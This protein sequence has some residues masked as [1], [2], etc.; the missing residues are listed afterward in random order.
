MAAKIPQTKPNGGA[1]SPSVPVN[2]GKVPSVSAAPSARP[3]AQT[4]APGLSLQDY[5]RQINDARRQLDSAQ[6]S[7]AQAHGTNNQEEIGRW[8]GEINRLQG[9][10]GDLTSQQTAALKA[11]TAK[12]AKANTA[13]PATPAPAGNSKAG[14]AAPAVPVN[15]NAAAAASNT[16][17]NTAKTVAT[18]NTKKTS[19]TSNT[20]TQQKTQ[21]TATPQTQVQTQAQPQATLPIPSIDDINSQYQQRMTDSSGMIND[22]FA[23]QLA[24]QQAQ[25]KS[26]YDQNLADLEA[27]RGQIGRNYQ[28]SAND[29]AIQYERNRRNLNEQAMVNGLNTGTG[30]QQQLALNQQ[31]L[32][33]FGGLRGQE[34]QAYTNADMEL[35]KLKTNYQNQIAQAIA[36]NDFKKAAALVDNYNTQQNWLTD[37]LNQIRG[38][39]IQNFFNEQGH[40]WDVEGR[41]DTQAFNAGESQK[42]R[43]FETSERLGRQD[44][45]KAE[46]EA[47]QEYETGVRKEGYAQ[48]EK[49]QAHDD[50][51]NLM[52]YL[53]QFGDFSLLGKLAG[54]DAQKQ[55]ELIYALQNPAQA[56]AAGKLSKKDYFLLTGQMPPE[57]NPGGDTG[58]SR[59]WGFPGLY[60]DDGTPKVP[61]VERTVGLV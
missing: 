11:A 23:N 3:Q 48:K 1:S 47:G 51:W 13:K 29:L 27:A 25:L 26:A 52:E 5:D 12:T 37:Q 34:A 53:G 21:Q 24:A 57:Y 33:A 59:Q 50:Q 35:A 2:T 18:A 30:S 49:E 38:Y 22:L 32:T 36:D 17:A 20:K 41:E 28:N 15:P 42:S 6:N 31:Y 56:Y 45:S 46:R 60:N 7:L 14:V 4:Q 16:A 43:E 19:S 44:F 61:D 55:A 40:G 39:S 10:I 9:T 58:N 54:K 8:Q